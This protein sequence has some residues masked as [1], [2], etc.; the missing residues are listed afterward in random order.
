MSEFITVYSAEIARRLTSRPFLIGLLIGAIGLF[1]LIRA[2]QLIGSAYT[3]QARAL[4]LSGDPRLTKR[5]KQLLSKDFT[6]VATAPA[7]TVPTPAYLKAH[8]NAKGLLELRRA[9]DGL[10]AI[11]YSKDPGD[12]NARDIQSDLLPLRLQTTLH[13]SAARVTRYWKAPVVIQSISSKFGN[14]EQSN[15]ARVIAY[16]MLF[17]LYILIVLN[18]QLIMSSIAEEKTS[19]IAE[20]LVASVNPNA[21]LWGKIAASATLAL[22][23]LAMWAIVGALAGNNPAAAAAAASSSHSGGLEFSIGDVRPAELLGFIVFFIL[24]YLEMATLF[25]AVGSL[26]NRTEDLGSISGPLF[27]PVIGG[28]MI[29]ILGLAVPDSPVVVAASF[30]PLVSPFV[31]FTRIVVSTVPAWQLALSIV[32]NILAVLAIAWI[33]A[34]LYRVGMLL[35]GRTPKFSQILKVLQT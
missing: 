15:S 7:G 28:F 27:I 19:R 24:A 4:I 25:A 14:A 31:M 33:G 9:H 20:L 6:I 29:G 3:S 13:V 23:Q 11:I 18:S 16:L 35:Y 17:I 30:V 10:R 21:L 12:F 34:R 26:I 22:I 32:L 2:P 5:A 8:H 1:A